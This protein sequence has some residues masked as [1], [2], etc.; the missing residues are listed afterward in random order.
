MRIS[1]ERGGYYFPEYTAQGR[2]SAEGYGIATN[3]A[4]ALKVEY[5]DIIAGALQEIAVVVCCLAFFVV[6]EPQ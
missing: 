2:R 1:T 6:L 5:N 3:L 4:K